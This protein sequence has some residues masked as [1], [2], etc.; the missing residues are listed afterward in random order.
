MKLTKKETD[1]LIAIA[2]Q[3]LECMGG[4]TPADLHDDNM[5]WFNSED[6]VRDLKISNAQARGIMSALFSKHLIADGGGSDWYLTDSGIDEAER[7][8]KEDAKEAES[9]PIEGERHERP[10]APLNEREKLTLISLARA[11][12]IDPDLTFT[13][14]N[15]IAW[16]GIDRVEAAVILQ[17]LKNK[18]VIYLPSQDS[19]GPTQWRLTALGTAT[20]EGLEVFTP[21][22][23]SVMLTKGEADSLLDLADIVH[24]EQ[25]YFTTANLVDWW[26]IDRLVAS[27]LVVEL[28]NK[29]VIDIPEPSLDGK[30]PLWTITPLGFGVV[31]ELKQGKRGKPSPVRLTSS[32]LIE[33][34][35]LAPNDHDLILQKGRLPVGEPVPEGWRV[36]KGNI[37]NNL[38]ARIAYRFECA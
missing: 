20:A 14:A 25:P 7:L 13:S 38:V 31:E 22:P 24:G 16:F 34:D 10:S 15:L 28:W 27:R 3:G 12:E 32:K 29:G 30:L 6:L 36:L 18:A 11:H 19:R 1:A 8:D 4:E 37:E 5:S 17:G 33:G 9:G 2:Y 21:R 23:S 26:E 35:P